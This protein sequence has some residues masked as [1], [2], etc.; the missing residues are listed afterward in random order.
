MLPLKD[1]SPQSAVPPRPSFAKPRRRIPAPQMRQPAVTEIQPPVLPDLRPPS[2]PAI[3]APPAPS[4]LGQ[5]AWLG[6]WLAA[7]ATVALSL[8]AAKG[9]RAQASLSG[10]ER[11]ETVVHPGAALSRVQLAQLL[12]LP[13]RSPQSELRNQLAQPYCRLA[14]L[15]VRAG[16]IAQ[17]E[18]YP[19][20]FDPQTWLVLLFEEEEYAG[21]AFAFHRF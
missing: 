9:Q 11:C 15:E 3:A 17:R 7:L 14:D 16:V 13:E 2:A 5:T 4:W 21:Y 1:R 10:H 19:L 18:A 20:A 12:T 6:G 8:S